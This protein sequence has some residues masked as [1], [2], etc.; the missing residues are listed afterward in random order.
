MR[1]YSPALLTFSALLVILIPFPVKALPFHKNCTS[2]QSYFNSSRWGNSTYYS[3]FE[4]QEIYITYNYNYTTKPRE[5][6]WGTE[7]VANK[8]GINS[9]SCCGGYIKE[10]SPMGTRVCEGSI[11]YNTK[12]DRKLSWNSYGMLGQVCRWR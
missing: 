2:M 3:G 9:L 5:D 1:S 7:P 11:T 8:T 12:M 10:T 4:N 6:G